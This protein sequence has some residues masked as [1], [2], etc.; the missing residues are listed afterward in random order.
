MTSQRFDRPEASEGWRQRIM[1]ERHAAIK[2]Y[3]VVSA[4]P[5]RPTPKPQSVSGSSRPSSSRSTAE[6]KRVVAAL[7]AT[8]V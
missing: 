1:I 5:P 2:H 7:E 3:V 4:Q 6:K 8:L